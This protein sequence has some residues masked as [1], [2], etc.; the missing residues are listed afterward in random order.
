M[1]PKDRITPTVGITPAL[2]E[3][4][5][6]RRRLMRGLAKQEGRFGPPRNDLTPKFLL[7]TRAT[8]SLKPAPRRVRRN[9]P[10]QVAR[11][12]ASIE[13]YGCLPILITAEGVII[14]GHLAYEAAKLMGLRGRPNSKVDLH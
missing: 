5:R 12:I 6:K 3:E 13:L 14:Q 8:D 9:D 11:I 1:K 7:E 10:V 2:A 4:F